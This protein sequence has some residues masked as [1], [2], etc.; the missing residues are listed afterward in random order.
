MSGLVTENQQSSSSSSLPSRQSQLVNDANIRSRRRHSALLTLLT[1]SDLHKLCCASHNAR[2]TSP[3]AHVHRFSAWHVN[4]TTVKKILGLLV[5]IVLAWLRD[6]WLQLQ[7][8]NVFNRSLSRSHHAKT[9]TRT[10]FPLGCRQVAVQVDLTS[11]SV[12]EWLMRVG[13]S[14]GTSVAAFHD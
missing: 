7:G 1:P 10:R 12:R 13:Y 5:S 11:N 2:D 8:P 4:I 9:M 14:V 6:S 3:I